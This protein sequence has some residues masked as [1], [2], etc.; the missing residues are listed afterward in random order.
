MSTNIINGF[1]V[2]RSYSVT[3]MATRESSDLS[4]INHVTQIQNTLTHNLSSVRWTVSG[5]VFVIDVT[6]ADD[7]SEE[8]CAGKAFLITKYLEARGYTVGN[9]GLS[10]NE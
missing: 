2:R 5:G 7:E 9:Y 1:V 10:G 3:L 8:D 4:V 6:V